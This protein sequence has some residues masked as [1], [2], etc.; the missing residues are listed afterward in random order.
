MPEQGCQQIN[1]YVFFWSIWQLPIFQIFCASFASSQTWKLS[2]RLSIVHKPGLWYG[3]KSSPVRPRWTNRSTTVSM[4]IK[5]LAY[6]VWLAGPRI[7]SSCLHPISKDYQHTKARPGALYIMSIASILE[8]IGL[9]LSRYAKSCLAWKELHPLRQA[10]QQ[11]IFQVSHWVDNEQ[12]AR[13]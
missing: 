4:E 3:W 5:L 2:S 1:E 13:R 6:F 11:G 9:D 10:G 8:I 7:V 12:M